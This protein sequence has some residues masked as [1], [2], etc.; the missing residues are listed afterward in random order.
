[1]RRIVI[2]GGGMTGLALA[3]LRNQSP[4]P[5]DDILVLEEGPSPGGSLR[6]LR[7]EGFVLEA[8]PHTLRTTPES[9]RL[10]EALGLGS[11]VLATDPKAPRWIVRGG[12]PRSIVPGPSA[13]FTR[14]VS[15]RGRL[16]G[17][18]EPWV[19]PRPADL[20]DETVHGFFARRFGEEIARGVAG[21]LAAGVWADD[22]GTLSMRSA[23]PEL[24][25]A[26]ARCG[27]VL[28]GLRRTAA[29]AGT[30]FRA[31]TLS[32]RDGLGSLAERLA[33]RSGRAGV[34]VELNAEVEAV[35]GPFE[36]EGN[37]GVWKVRIADGTV[38][39]ADTLVSTLDAP[40]LADLLGSRLPRS[41]AALAGLSYSRIAVV[42]QAFR[43]ERPGASPRGFGV[44]FPRGEGF[45]ALGVLYLSSLFPSRA[46]RGVA[47]TSSFYGGALEPSIP[48]RTES[49]LLQLAEAEV[50]RLHPA[51]GPRVHGRVLKWPAALPRLPVGHHA[52]LAL[53]ERDLESLNVGSGR[54]RLVVTGPWRDG[55]GLGR[56]IARAEELAPTL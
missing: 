18:R 30:A 15:L 43:P 10:V 53:L 37:G 47:Q 29:P 33:E 51:I 17:L 8:G 9:D 42:H 41:A 31:R 19:A 3:F 39:P 32:F 46:P 56:R 48:D 23:F 22:P 6:S 49:E 7:E 50:R 24:W 52:T 28:R 44:L 26:E 27:S 55:L 54:P 5:G 21:P 13:L 14:A 40:A 4:A 35:E 2:L 34:R 11:E 20:S 16:R 25:E 12:R 45:R 38:Y 36:G 1:M